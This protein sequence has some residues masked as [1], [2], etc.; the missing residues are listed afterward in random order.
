MG[1]GDQDDGVG[2]SAKVAILLR[3]KGEIDDDP[4]EHTRAELAPR[5]D[6]DLTEDGE[7][8]TRVQLATNEPVV[9]QVA[10]AAASGKLASVGVAWVLDAERTNI[11]ESGQKVGDED[12][13]GDDANKVVSDERPDREVG[14]MGDS[15]S[16]ESSQDEE[17]RVPCC[18]V[19]VSSHGRNT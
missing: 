1:E 12:V 16:G 19:L 15:A 17:S 14:A 13:G 11:A 18:D 7:G 5:L 2:N 9:E 3:D 8:D 10:G 6:V 4:A